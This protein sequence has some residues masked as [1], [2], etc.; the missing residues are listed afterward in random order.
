MLKPLKAALGKWTPRDAGGARDPAALLAAAWPEIVG[1]EVARNSHPIKIVDDMLVVVTRSS[2]WS[3][4][5]GYLSE[6]VV[7]AVRARL[8]R[9]GIAQLRFRVGSVPDRTRRPAAADDAPA[10]RR[11]AGSAPP[12][13]SA[14]QAVE[15]FRAAI[16]ERRRAKTAA[17]WKTCAGCAALI[18]PGEALLCITCINARAQ[19]RASATARLL[20]EAPWLG[21][22]GTAEL[23]EGLTYREYESIRAAL[24]SRWWETLARAGAAKRLSRDGRERLVASSYVVLQSKL[25]PEEISPAIVRNALGD[26]L[27]DLI[28]GTEPKN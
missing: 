16:D 11:A 6:H 24:L 12:A 23:V 3:Q 1:D 18:A 28:Y 21:Y 22:P 19:E 25:P 4:Q 2:G 13:E 15:R 26:E 20:F 9:A 7:A 5:L 17:G 10:P 14:E 8:P 27:H